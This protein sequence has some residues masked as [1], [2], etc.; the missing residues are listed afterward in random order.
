MDGMLF[1]KVFHMT[2]IGCYCF[3]I[4]FPVRFIL[5]RISYKYCYYLWLIVF[6]NLCIPFSIFSSFSL[7]PQRVM[8]FNAEHIE[9]EE[10]QEE[11]RE[12]EPG[13]VVFS[14]GGMSYR[15]KQQEVLPC[16]TEVSHAQITEAAEDAG[17][18]WNIIFPW[19]GKIWLLGIC[20]FAAYSIDA[21]VRLNRRI[22]RTDSV[23]LSK[24]ERI[25]ELDGLDSPFL[26]GVWHPTIY[27]PKDLEAEERNYIVAHE[28]CHRSRRDHLVKIV[29]Y[30]VTILHWFNPLVWFTYGLFC[31]D[32]EISCDE[33]ILEVSGE[34]VKKAYAKCLLKYAAKQNRNAMTSLNFGEPSVRSRIENILKY[35]KKGVIVTATA[36]LL[37]TFMAAGLLMRP[38]ESENSVKE[39]KGMTQGTK[40]VGNEVSGPHT[41]PVINNGGE[42]IQIGN[43]IYYMDGKHLYSDGKMLY[44]TQTDE[45]GTDY[46]YQYALDGS[47]SHQIMQGTLVGVSDDK[48]DFYYIAK[49]EGNPDYN[50]RK[51]TD[52]VYIGSI[53]TGGNGMNLD[54]L[55]TLIQAEEISSFHADAH[56]LLFAAGTYEGSAGYFYGDFYSY[57]LDTKQLKQAHLTDSDE[58][59][60]FGGKIYYEK[61][62]YQGD[63]ESALYRADFDL[64][65]EK[66]IG[67]AWKLLATDQDTHTLLVSRDGKLFCISPDGKKET[68]LLDMEDAGWKWDE[69]DTIK[70]TEVNLIKDTIYV[71]P[72]HWGY[73]E[74]SGWRDSLIESQYFQ[75]RSDGSAYQA[76]DPNAVLEEYYE[77]FSYLSDPM[78]GLPCNNPLEVGWNLEHI[79]DIRDN[80]ATM[81]YIPEEGTEENIY[82]IGKTEHYTLYGKGNFQ[83]M[84]LECGGK[85]AEIH[86]EYTSNYMTPP[87]L[88]EKDLDGDARNELTIKFNIKHGTGQYVDTFL[89]ADIQQDG[90]LY[91]YQFLEE[92]FIKQ[93]AEHLS[94]EKTEKG[95]QAF[96]DGQPALLYGK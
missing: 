14:Q 44:A 55:G 35:Q 30:A 88:L 62:F 12:T 4:V 71:K 9:I 39:D 79:T 77:T 38:V 21:A 64:S 73:R 32:M 85:Y 31:K 72:E 59:F 40:K 19:A 94:Y 42:I 22:R 11:V 2:L 27:L 6:M 15:K 47:E 60:V 86:Y 61:Y 17:I 89:L 82:L 53:K 74:G 51:N 76:W 54:V 33:K 56:T 57:N 81:S 45:N 1:S 90:K 20:I 10:V 29:V 92:D 13:I 7:I 67:K 37:T 58:F 87:E 65:E 66:L 43:D 93:L 75:V 63:G 36:I 68:C 48:E 18:S 5:K 23:F 25:V 50:N 70:F 3:L 83:S 24:K 26:W 16:D 46:I 96:V 49:G 69:Y 34:N 8:E 95:I 41:L 78:P 28:K 80:F 91:V 52:G 84:L